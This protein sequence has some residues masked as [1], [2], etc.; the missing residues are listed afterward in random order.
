[1][2]RRTTVNGRCHR[3]YATPPV[4]G[5]RHSDESDAASARAAGVDAE[6]R[7]GGDAGAAAGGVVDGSQAG[8]AALCRYVEDDVAAE[9]AVSEEDVSVVSRNRVDVVL[10][11]PRLVIDVAQNSVAIGGAS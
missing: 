5:G 10:G 8:D 7:C 1:M 3:A 6:A 11:G 9:R 4:A 2:R